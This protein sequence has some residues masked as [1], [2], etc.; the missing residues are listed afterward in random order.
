MQKL[1]YLLYMREYAYNK[2][3]FYKYELYVF[4]YKYIIGELKLG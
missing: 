2:G 1:S 3:I 4:T